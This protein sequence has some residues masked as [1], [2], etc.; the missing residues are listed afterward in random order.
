MM[1]TKKYSGFVTVKTNRWKCLLALLF[2]KRVGID[3]GGKIIAQGLMLGDTFYPIVID[4]A[5]RGK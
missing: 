5:Y 3:D 4:A 1:L 2:G